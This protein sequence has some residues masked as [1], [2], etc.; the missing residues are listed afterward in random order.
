MWITT[1]HVDGPRDCLQKY[2]RIVLYQQ[3]Q[4][5]LIWDTVYFFEIT[6]FVIVS[7]KLKNR[8]FWA[9]KYYDFTEMINQA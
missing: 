8:K 1:L 4:E 5:N 3:S 6:F 7:T 2:G 9:S